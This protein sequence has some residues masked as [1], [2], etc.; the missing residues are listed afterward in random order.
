MKNMWMCQTRQG[1][2]GLVHVQKKPMAGIIRPALKNTFYAE[3]RVGV[4]AALAEAPGVG[5]DL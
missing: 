5:N 2:P 1:T 4:D 3:A